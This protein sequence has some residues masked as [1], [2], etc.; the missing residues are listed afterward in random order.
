MQIFLKSFS[1]FGL[2]KVVYQPLIYIKY[3]ANIGD[4]DY[5]KDKFCKGKS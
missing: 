2:L 4:I 3:L 5:V 1:T